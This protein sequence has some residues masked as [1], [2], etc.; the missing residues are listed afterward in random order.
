VKLHL[1]LR[2]DLLGLSDATLAEYYEAVWDLREKLGLEPRWS[3]PIFMVR[4]PIRHPFFYRFLQ[5][6]SSSGGPPEMSITLSALIAVS[7]QLSSFFTRWNRGASVFLLNCELLDLQ[8][9]LERRVKMKD[10]RP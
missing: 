10:V 2:S 5:F 7:P 4:P 8:D 1:S 9:E 6:F 3:D